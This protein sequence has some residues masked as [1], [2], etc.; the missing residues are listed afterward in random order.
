[1]NLYS[2]KEGDAWQI[3]VTVVTIVMGLFLIF[4]M[5]CCLKEKCCKRSTTKVD[6]EIVNDIFQ[7]RTGGMHVVT[8]DEND[9]VNN[10]SLQIEDF[11][12]ETEPDP[13]LEEQED[14]DIIK[15]AE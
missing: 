11:K 3:V 1:M 6:P 5:Y 4:A 15:K 13:D 9:Q 10:T 7:N 8:Q 12:E 14:L 2:G